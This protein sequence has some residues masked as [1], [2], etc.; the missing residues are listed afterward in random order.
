MTVL[1]LAGGDVHRDFEAEAEVTS[2]RCFPFHWIVSV[3]DWLSGGC[4]CRLSAVCSGKADWN[5]L[6]QVRRFEASAK[7]SFGPH[8][9]H[10]IQVVSVWREEGD[11]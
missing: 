5:Q 1:P 10:E 9:F 2:G 11:G 7:S 3:M 8:D 6:S 4:C